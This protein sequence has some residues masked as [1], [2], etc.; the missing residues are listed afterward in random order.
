MDLSDRMK[1]FERTTDSFLAHRTPAI[2]RFDG[3][4]FH[5]FTNGFNKPFDATVLHAMKMAAGALV[6]DIPCAKLAYTQ[7]D[8]I[9]LLLIDYTAFNTLQAFD[10]EVKKLCSVGAS[11][12]TAAC[13]KAIFEAYE[14]EE[15][16]ERKELLKSKLFRATFDG[17]CFNVPRE[18]VANYFLHRFKD[19]QR[20]GIQSIGQSKFSH[21][22]LAG[23]SCPQIVAK[24]RD[25]GVNPQADY[26]AAGRNGS[27]ALRRD[28][29]NGRTAIVVESLDNVWVPADTVAAFVSPPPP[30]EPV[31]IARVTRVMQPHSEAL[32][33]S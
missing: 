16:P 24:L 9:S 11:I 8:E 27:I 26:P 3:R 17:R 2:C 13:N 19:A 28:Q 14:K 18:E 20:N 7:S 25:I 12:A 21:K 31:T 1:K 22:E 29:G 10:G 4:A 6:A 33:K 30:E 5:T 23:V 32:N 15:N